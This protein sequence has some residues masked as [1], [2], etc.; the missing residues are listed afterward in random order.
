MPL[1]AKMLMFGVR[2]FKVG[3]ELEGAFELAIHK[4]EKDAKNPQPKPNPEM[5]KIQG[6]Q[7]IAQQKLQ[8]D[9]QMQREK[10]Q[11]DLAVEAAEAKTQED[12]LRMQAQVDA[13]QGQVDAEVE[14]FKINLQGQMDMA[15]AKLESET[16]IAVA[17]IQAKAQLQ[18]ASIS[19]SDEDSGSESADAD[20]NVVKQPSMADL[21]TTV[22]TQLQQALASNT[23][24]IAQSHQMLA[25]AMSKPKQVVR[26]EQGNIVGVH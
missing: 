10:M 12:R 9:M 8:G 25:Q 15:R 21:L 23:Q 17:Q 16:K 4:L 19:K 14:K 22:V 3:K 11:A 1:M 18:S 7:Q 5:L 26:D 24:G 2:G 20:G 6:E 13:H